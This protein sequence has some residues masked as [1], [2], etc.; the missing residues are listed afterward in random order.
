MPLACAIS[1]F[2]IPAD[3]IRECEPVL[4]DFPISATQEPG[5]LSSSVWHNTKNKEGF[6]RMTFFESVETMEAFYDKIAKSDAL[7]FAIQK[8]GLVPDV[9]AT[10]V[11]SSFG[12]KPR[13]IHKSQFLS[14]S[15]RSED[16]GMG[17]DWVDKLSNNFE[18][19]SVI[20][21]FEGGV[22]GR[23]LNEEDTILG[24]AMWHDEASFK[25]SV[26]DMP[27][28]EIDLYKLYR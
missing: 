26:P 23:S 6:L 2:S 9:V 14:F 12:F 10:T 13:D 24:M 3:R 17:Q 20:P 21:G 16:P 5:F 11:E 4:G 22:V 28:Y 25:R 27:D 15:K 19:I 1:R 7:V 8:F 18:E